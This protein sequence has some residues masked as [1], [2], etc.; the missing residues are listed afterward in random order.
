MLLYD[1]SSDQSITM[2]PLSYFSIQPYKRAQ[3]G[4]SWEHILYITTKKKKKPTKKPKKTTTTK[5][6]KNNNNKKN[7]TINNNNKHT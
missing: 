6:Q 3:Q 2:Y 4:Y 7:K 1:G 5:K